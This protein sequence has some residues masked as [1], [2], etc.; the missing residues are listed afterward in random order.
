MLTDTD[1][2]YLAGIIDGEGSLMIDRTLSKTGRKINY[3]SRL[4]IATTSTNLRDN[5]LAR[6]PHITSHNS[7]R[8]GKHQVEAFNI[9]CR[10]RTLVPLLHQIMPYLVIKK[11]QAE[12]VLNFEE[13]KK[14]NKRNYVELD[15]FKHEIRQLNRRGSEEYFEAFS[16]KLDAIWEVKLEEY[17]EKVKLHNEKESNRHCPVCNKNM[18]HTHH[19]KIFCSNACK[20][21]DWRKKKKEGN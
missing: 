2:A 12:V 7:H 6:F 17:N 3:S 15:K 11:Q 13:Y 14:L 1:F 18:A 16:D 9:H 4:S 8:T 19:L 5:L 10:G 20:L 21:K